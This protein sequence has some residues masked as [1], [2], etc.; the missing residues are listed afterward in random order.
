[1]EPNIVFR[2]VTVATSSADTD[3]RLVLV[4]GRLAAVLVRLQDDIHDDELRGTWFLEA[5]FGGLPPPAEQ[6]TFATLEDAADWISSCRSDGGTVAALSRTGLWI[7]IG[8]IEFAQYLA[9]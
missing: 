1:V 6:G 2:P 9:A 4:G 5:V 8:L 7:A 3:G